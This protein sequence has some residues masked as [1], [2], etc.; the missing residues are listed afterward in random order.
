MGSLAIQHS[1]NY[2]HF[3]Q[4][5]WE[6]LRKYQ[7]LAGKVLG[8]SRVAELQDVVQNLEKTSNVRDLAELLVP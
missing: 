1:N 4:L 2:N 6:K 8:E 3:Y 5:K 7:I